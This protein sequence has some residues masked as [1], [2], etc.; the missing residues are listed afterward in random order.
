MFLQREIP[1]EKWW[2]DNPWHMG[3]ARRIK[4]LHKNWQAIYR[5]VVVL[6]N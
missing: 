5:M 6:T 1:P 4:H 2:R 3:I